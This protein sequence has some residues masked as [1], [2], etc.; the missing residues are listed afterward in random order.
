MPPPTTLQFVADRGDARLRLDQVLVRRITEVSRL[1]RNVAQ[2]WIAS[3]AVTVDGRVMRRTAAP[4]RDG[5]AVV[6]VLPPDAVLRERP[7]AEAGDLDLLYEDEWLLAVNKPAGVVVHPSYK[8][9]HHTLL[10][11]VL[12]RIRDRS[13]VSPGILT[14]LDKDT[15]GI[16]VI[17]LS[18]QV[19]AALQ[20]SASAGEVSKQY[21]AAVN[22]TPDPPVGVIS[23]PLGRDPADR[24][25]V[26]V[27]PAGAPSETRYELLETNAG[28]SMVRCELV[29][30]RTHQI[31]VHLA[32]RGWPVVGDRL[33]GSADARINRQALHAWRVML[34]H[35]VTG[36]LVHVEAPV[37]ADL[38]GLV[39]QNF[40]L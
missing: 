27:T 3:G 10:N 22:G 2:R 9:H 26:I 6:V 25:R 38:L 33:Y 34:Q 37:P 19:H 4:V 39:P 18:A 1:S 5:A 13:H 28:T 23:A 29:T 16:V 12:W 20:R 30:G 32:S 21:M 31:R 14:R 8:H 17:A 15:S 11:R 40:T 24:R 36:A 7:D 35:P